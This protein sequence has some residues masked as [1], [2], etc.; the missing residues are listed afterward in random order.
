[1]A[2]LEWKSTCCNPFN[3]C[4]HTSKRKNLRPVTK[5]MCE[6][7]P[8]IS[9]GARI[10]DSCRKKPSVL[11]VPDVYVPG[12]LASSPCLLNEPGDEATAECDIN[13][14]CDTEK[15]VDYSVCSLQQA[16]DPSLFAGDD[17]W[18][19]LTSINQCLK[20]FGRHQL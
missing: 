2:E 16:D 13:S 11:I 10:C 4:G 7:V 6:K 20:E 1:M 9:I 17:P 3:V 18:P 15:L 19:S 8:H 14:D 5:W 12:E